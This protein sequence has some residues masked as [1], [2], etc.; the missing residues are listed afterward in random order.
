MIGQLLMNKANYDL[1][2]SH[3]VSP[4]EDPIQHKLMDKIIQ[5]TRAEIPEIYLGEIKYEVE[6]E[7]GKFLITLVCKLDGVERDDTI[8]DY[9]T[10][11]S[12]YKDTE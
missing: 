2:Y 8:A 10:S 11:K 5:S 7:Y 1:I 12:R 3:F 6:V 4:V 9:K